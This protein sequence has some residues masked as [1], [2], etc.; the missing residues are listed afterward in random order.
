MDKNN[1]DHDIY[2]NKNCNFLN[3]FQD[4]IGKSY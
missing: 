4:N 1:K 2:T 3:C